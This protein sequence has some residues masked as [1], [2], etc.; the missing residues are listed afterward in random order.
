MLSC[1]LFSYIYERES[2]VYTSNT[3]EM[4]KIFTTKLKYQFPHESKTIRPITVS[5]QKNRHHSP[6]DELRILS[7]GLMNSTLEKMNY[8]RQS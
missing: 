4:Y 2:V 1:D 3:N 8:E 5:P 7:L 6:R